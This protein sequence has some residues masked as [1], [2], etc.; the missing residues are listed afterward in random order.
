MITFEQAV[1]AILN[2]KT[3][4]YVGTLDHPESFVP[5]VIGKHH[6][7][8]SLIYTYSRVNE[9]GT[10]PKES[11]WAITG[12]SSRTFRLDDVYSTHQEV[13]NAIVARKQEEIRKLM[14]LA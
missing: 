4:Y 11:V 13:V 7:I 12:E 9:T 14:E 3:L 1:D 8:Q 2:K 10:K 5:K 6:V